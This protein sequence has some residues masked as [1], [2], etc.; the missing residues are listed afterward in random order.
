M[1]WAGDGW[2]YYE[3]EKNRCEVGLTLCN[4][5]MLKQIRSLLLRFGIKT[6]IN[7]GIAKCNGKEFDSWTISIRDI[8]NI[9]KFYNNIKIPLA[10]KQNNLKA[11]L[12]SGKNNIGAYSDNFPVELWDRVKEKSIEKGFTFNSLMKLIGEDKNTFQYDKSKDRY[13]EEASWYPIANDR[14]NPGVKWLQIT[15]RKLRLLG[16]VLQDQFMID[17]AEGDIYFDEVTSIEPIGKCQCY[18]LEIPDGHNFVAEDTIVHNTSM[19]C[20]MAYE[21]ADDSMNNA[22]CI[23]HSI[24]DSARFIIYKWVCNAA[25]EMNLQLN[26]VSNPN[27]WATQPGGEYVKDIRQTAYNKIIKMVQ[28]GQLVIKDASDG[29]GL[30][31]TESLIKYYRDIYPEK[32]IVLFLDNFHKLPDNAEIQGHERV[33]RLS[34]QLKNMTVTQRCT[35]VSTVEYR[36]LQP[37]EKPSNLAIAESRALAYDASVICHL[38]N[39][40]HNNSAAEAVLVHHNKQGEVLPRIWCKFGKN[41]VSGYEGRE[42]LDLHPSHA[43]LK[44]VNLEIAEQEQR[45]RIMYL[46]ENKDIVM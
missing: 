6:N 19:C 44:A 38:Y 35:I 23:Y 43:R 12:D 42:F 18:D 7:Y 10:Y 28:N 4:Y 29:N 17:I 20:Q 27:Y 34:N 45:D 21:I 1:F 26:H 2:V 25:E 40:L 9:K 3:E 41:K 22:I 14:N 13:K 46:K 24:D 8:E 31:Y 32:N 5:K 33:K 11:I 16:Y 36:K 30:A 15:P 37:G 39:D